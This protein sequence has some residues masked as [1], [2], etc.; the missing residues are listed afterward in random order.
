MENIGKTSILEVEHYVYRIAPDN[1]GT[2]M[3]ISE[4]DLFLIKAWAKKKKKTLQTVLH[5]MV[6]QAT[7]CWDEKHEFQITDM[8]ERAVA[9]EHV[10]GLYFKRYGPLPVVKRR[11]LDKPDS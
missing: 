10:V 7:K 9:A 5:A 3:K 6:G 1:Y 4:P 2:N 11:T 8:E